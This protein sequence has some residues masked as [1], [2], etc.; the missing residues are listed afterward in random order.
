VGR[1]VPYKGFPVL[2]EAMRDLDAQLVIIGEGPQRRQLEQQILES[3]L[4][5]RVV[6]AGR[7]DA[8]ELRIMLRSAN[9]FA[10]PSILPSETFGIAQLEAMACGLPVVN[11]SLPTGVPWVARHEREALTVPPGDSQALAY[12]LRDLLDQPALARQLG[13]AGKLRARTLFSH[14][15]FA[16]RIRNLYG[17]ILMERS[18]ARARQPMPSAVSKA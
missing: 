17:R 13:E 11:T 16:K 8:D 9:V 3:G 4:S 10:F 14:E 7:V 1:L 2:I 18:G 6:L 15:Q 12:A 5:D